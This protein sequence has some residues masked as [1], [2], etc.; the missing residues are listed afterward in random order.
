MWVEYLRYSCPFSILSDDMISD[1]NMFGF[2]M[3]EG[4]LRK[5]SG[6]LVIDKELR[7]DRIVG[8]KFP[9]GGCTAILRRELLPMWL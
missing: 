1:V 7:G 3:G 2:L 8:D 6:G 9:G 4:I 5:A